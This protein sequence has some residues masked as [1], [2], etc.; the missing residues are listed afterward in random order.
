MDGVNFEHLAIS[1]GMTRWIAQYSLSDFKNLFKSGTKIGIMIESV[2]LRLG[3]LPSHF[4]NS[5]LV[6]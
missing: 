4:E 2:L 6:A 1:S 3:V 5:G